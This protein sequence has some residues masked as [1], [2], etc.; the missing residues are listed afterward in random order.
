MK[1]KFWTVCVALISTSLLAQQDTNTPAAAPA[2]APAAPPAAMAPS[3]TDSNSAPAA[4]PET[5]PAA[6]TNAPAAETPKPKAKHKKKSTAHAPELKTVPLV[7]GAAVV[8]ISPSSHVNVRGKAGLKGEII[9]RLTNGEP[10]TVIEEIRLKNSQTNEPSAWAKVVLPAK[11]HTWVKSSYIDETG[12][13]VKPKT[14]NLQMRGGPGENYS[15]LGTLQGGDP[16]TEISTKKGWTEIE[17]PA[18]ASAYIAAQYLTQDPVALAAAAGLSAPTNTE[19]IA[20]NDMA[21]EAGTNPPE[22]SGNMAS[23]GT[24]D[25]TSTTSAVVGPPPPR[26]VEREGYV[27]GT[28]S[29]QAPTEYELVSPDNHKIIDY[30]YSKS[31]EV[32]LS[33]YKGMHIIV[34]G[35]EGMDERWKATPVITIQRIQVIE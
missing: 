8:Q 21:T 17:T 5:A 3:A 11:A 1:T 4:A 7:A 32:D 34:T 28:K 2:E 20:E 31:D 24:N 16:V 25:Q 23:A 13:M 12:K 35:I 30:L 26:I 22:M 6:A 27:V 14:K 29:I 9:T 33:R 19:T 10:V 15:V 18:G